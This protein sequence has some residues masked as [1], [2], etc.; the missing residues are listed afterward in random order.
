MDWVDYAFILAAYVVAS[1]IKGLT[2]I[3]F[4]TSCLPIMALRLD[5]RIAIPLVIIPSIVS[6]LVVMFQAGSFREAFRRFWPLYLAS[7]PGLLA[8]LA[9]LVAIDVDA[10][11]A[12]LG[13]V[14]VVYALWALANQPLALTAEWERRLNVPIGL[15]TGFVNGLTGS[16]VM[17]VL[18]YLLALNLNKNTFVQAINLSFTLSSLV[19]LVG[20]NR[21]GYLP[22]GN[23]MVAV[24][25]LVP[26]MTIVYLAGKF[27]RRLAGSIHRRLVLSF[28][29]VMGMLLLGRVFS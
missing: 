21:L 23:V 8:G 9:I 7:F 2:G 15:G 1:A 20:V 13:L 24:A 18:P 29:L 16:Q 14:L 3:G 4:S 25:G 10:A 27:Q 26:V 22:A 28:L 12:I 17:P 11:R 6:N 5:L 19:M